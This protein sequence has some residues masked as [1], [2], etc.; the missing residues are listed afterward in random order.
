VHDLNDVLWIGGPPGAGKT[1]VARR[2]ARH[3]GARLYSA[4]TR[5]WVHRSRAE[6]AGDAAALE[7]QRR[8]PTRHWDD[9][10]DDDLIAM[11]LHAVRGPM[12]LEDVEALPPQ[13]L[14][15]AEGTT[16]PAR[17][18]GENALW[19]L[20]HDRATDRLARALTA[21]I[22]EEAAANDLPTLVASR[23]VDETVAN[24]EAHFT[25][26]LASASLAHA[27]DDRAAL[28]HE[29]NQSIV[30]QVRGY[31]ANAWA[32]GDPEGVTQRFVCECA[33]RD[34]I[35][36]VVVALGVASLGPV[37]APEHD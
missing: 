32:S 15:I 35:E 27:R 11:S 36:E 28:L 3:Y 30:E 20:P 18:V 14:V 24:V 7:W 10:T 25:N 2:L 6:A 19:L 5:T 13:P 16:L 34:C 4:D 22:L 29:Y 9:V 17:S 37:T 1:T 31:Y 21:V 8:R 23:S 12:V 26:R 33:R